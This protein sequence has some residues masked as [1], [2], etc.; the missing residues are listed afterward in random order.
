MTHIAFV[1]PD[2]EMVDTV[3]RAWALHERIFGKSE[4]LSYSV[5]F[6]VEPDEVL[7]RHF[8]ADVIVCR[9]GTAAA[10]KEHHCLIPVVEVPI[11]S[12]DMGFSIRR[13]LKENGSLP[14]G[15]VGTINTIRAAY[16]IKKNF[17][18]S[19]KP[20]PTSSVHISDLVAGMERAVA[21][22]CGLIL[23]GHS[24]CNYCAD[25]G[26]PAGLIYS[27]VESVFLAITE[28]K[29]CALVAHQE[30]ENSLIFRGIVENVFD[31][32]IAVDGDNR[33]RTFNPAAE[34][35]LGR[36]A[37]DCVGHSVAQALP[38]S[39]LTAILSGDKSCTNEII[40]VGNVNLVVNCMQMTQGDR[41][42]GTLT[43]FQAAGTYA[44]VEGRL[45]E[46]L[47]ASGHTA[48]YRFSGILGESPE[49]LSAIRR[50]QRFARVDSNVLLLGE[51]GTGKELFAQSIHNDSN[52]AGRAFVAVN[53]AT[54]PENLMESELF[55]YEEG[56]FTGASRKGKEGLFEAAHEGTIFLDEIS[57]MPL[58]MQSRLL[59]V[60]QEREVR[61]VGG[62]R[63]IPIDVRIICATNRNLPQMIAEGKFREDLY[64]R[65]NVL[66][67]TLPP[68]RERGKDAALIMRH[69]L[70]YYAHKFGKGEITLSEEAA[71]LASRYTWPGNIRELR[72]IC[73]QL[74][75]LCEEDEIT[76]ADL[77]AALP[78]GRADA[79]AGRPEG[80]RPLPEK[81]AADSLRDME[82]ERIREVVS[83][84]ASR[85]EAAELLGISR[86]TLWR[87]CRELGIG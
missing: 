53:C 70:A 28:A 42:L 15:V 37:K 24:T 68:V 64:Y 86:A 32:V 83:R 81:A 85:Q 4:D 60:I 87:R 66:S 25:H 40:R 49:I 1:M 13:A 29:R 8:D 61:R 18:V 17:P 51:S 16:F 69:Y 10:L 50:A 54:I 52:R 7:S 30:Q 72:N 78:A 79:A 5:D 26:I 22:G 71:A 67:V 14:I 12:A 34:R 80:T 55:G 63:V 6:A 48:K 38:E 23:S 3:H 82:R 56:A 47:R 41:R 2:P 43:T 44:D 74:A 65:L 33:I 76:A 11:T 20:F 31:G 84:T 77:S 45:R 21:D 46:R 58:H 59:R 19:V 36:T 57:E 35:L 75:V 73:E 9:G 62:S 27:S 39:R